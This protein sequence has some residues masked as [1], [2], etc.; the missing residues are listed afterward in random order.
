MLL[1]W[2]SSHQTSSIHVV[3]SLSFIRWNVPIKFLGVNYHFRL[4]IR[5]AQST[6]SQRPSAFDQYTTASISSFSVSFTFIYPEFMNLE[7]VIKLYYFCLS[8]SGLD[9]RQGWN[10]LNMLIS[11]LS[12]LILNFIY[13]L[14]VLSK[15][16]IDLF[17]RTILHMLSRLIKSSSVSCGEKRGKVTRSGLKQWKLE[18]RFVSGT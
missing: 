11:E 9:I 18:N 15:K 2:I 8:L 1:F 7:S 17:C 4:S 13:K 14:I 10:K 16:L 6:G 3:I 12:S 5:H